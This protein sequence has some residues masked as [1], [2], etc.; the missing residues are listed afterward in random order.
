MMNIQKNS[1]QMPSTKA[2]T[3]SKDYCDLLYAWLQIKSSKP[4]AFGEERIVEKE[5][6]NWSLIERDFTIEVEGKPVKRM[7]RKT[8]AKNFEWLVEHK[9]IRF[10][11]EQ[12]AYVLTAIDSSNA[13]LVEYNTLACLMNVLQ[14]R[15][16]S[17]YIY[18]LNRYI[19]NC[20]EEYPIKLSH[21]KDYIG[22]TSNTNSNNVFIKDTFTILKKLGLMD[23]ELKKL[24]NDRTM[25]Y[26]KWVSNVLPND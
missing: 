13:F 26:I 23:F 14:K 6:V 12:D 4:M 8:I 16:L 2:I 22:I 20:Y 5:F 18:V 19:A 24:D 21:L 25:Y 9:L 3:S 17:I 15:S 1:R 7:G 10:D 11:E